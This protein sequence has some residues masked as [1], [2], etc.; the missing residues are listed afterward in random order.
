MADLDS[1]VE[2]LADELSRRGFI[3]TITRNAHYPSLTVDHPEVGRLSETIY[4]ALA[5]DEPW[6]WW[7]WA[8]RIA[9]AADVQATAD[10]VAH[11][12]RT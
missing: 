1:H 8:E 7:S 10:A 9:P 11:V 6:F 2:A 4:V 5:R 3:V 12:L